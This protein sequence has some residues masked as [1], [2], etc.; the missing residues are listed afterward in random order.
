VQAARQAIHVAGLCLVLTGL[1]G[2]PVA[3]E[4]DAAAPGDAAALPAVDGLN[5]KIA[6]FGGAVEEQALY[7]GAGSVTLPLGQ[8][9]G[10]QLD[11][12]VTGFD[13]EGQGDVTIAGTAAHLF[14]RDPAQGLLGAYGHYIHADAFDGVDIFAGG[15]EGALYWGQFTLEGV[16]GVEGGEVDTSFGNFDI[17][18]RFFDV[19]QVAWYPVDD[20]KLSAGHSY[21]L[22][23]NSALFGAEW[24]VD[25]GGGIMA[26]G[27]ALRQWQRLRGRRRRRAGRLASLLRPA[28]QDPH[29]AASRRRSDCVVGWG[30][31][32]RGTRRAVAYSVLVARAAS[33]RLSAQREIS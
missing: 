29:P 7:G 22:G 2:S 15:V 9:F 8:W 23:E 20:L 16:A 13:S 18:T 21:S 28:A 31:H 3:A 24:G 30:T 11:G 32:D 33:G 14:W 6:G 4:P 26:S 19:A 25:A 1:L 5:A 10:L 17:D 12:L 27:V